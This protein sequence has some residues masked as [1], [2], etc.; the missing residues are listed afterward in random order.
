MPVKRVKDIH[1]SHAS[2]SVKD[3]HTKELRTPIFPMQKQLRTPT[4]PI[5]INT[6]S[7]KDT[8]FPQEAVK[9]THFSNQDQHNRVIRWHQLR[10][11]RAELVTLSLQLVGPITLPSSNRFIV[12]PKLHH[13]LA[14]TVVI[15][16][17]TCAW[18]DQWINGPEK[19][20]KTKY[21]NQKYSRFV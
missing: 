15:G 3:T 20:F 13:I 2:Q 8:H 14:Q 5:K 16:Q 18:V 10:P 4:F 17:I 12:I 1:I 6:K 9:D 11:V 19:W 7:V 21:Q